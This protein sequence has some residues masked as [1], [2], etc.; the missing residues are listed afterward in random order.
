MAAEL[1]KEL[2]IEMLRRMLRIRLFDEAAAGMQ[3]RGE[4]P[5]PMHTSIGQ[6][7]EVVGACMAL[8][9]T[10]YM[11]GNHR[12]HG[13]PIGK[14][15]ALKPLMAELLGKA[16]GVCRGHGGSM[17]L[18]DFSVGSLGESGIVGAGIP[19]A[20]GAA[21]SSRLR[22]SGQVALAFFGDGAANCGPFHESLNLAA[23]WSLPIVFLCEDNG[24][25]VTSRSTDMVSVQHISDRAVGYT[26]P[27]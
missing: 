3:A 20:T 24:F 5:G 13:H 19:I 9:D 4:L 17:H 26:V 1:S 14:G 7:A 18:A 15:A 22:G 21:L 10:D 23:I 27:G 2:T 16:T 11:T 8:T 6:E 25:A 12:S